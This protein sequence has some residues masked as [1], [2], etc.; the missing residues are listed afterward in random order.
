MVQNLNQAKMT[1]KNSQRDASIFTTTD[2]YKN[3]WKSRE[4]VLLVDKKYFRPTEVD[5]LLGD[6]SKARKILKWLPKKIFK[7]TS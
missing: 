2:A 3:G 4:T 1:K 6:S 7:V 5:N